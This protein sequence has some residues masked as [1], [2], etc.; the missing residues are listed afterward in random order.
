MKRTIKWFCKEVVS[1]DDILNYYLRYSIILVL[2]WLDWGL[3]LLLYSFVGYFLF[4]KNLFSSMFSNT[5]LN[6]V[7]IIQGN[8]NVLCYYLHISYDKIVPLSGLLLVKKN[9]N[10]LLLKNLL[11]RWKFNLNFYDNMDFL[12]FF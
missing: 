6:L 1:F 4:K 10:T 8:K 5:E 12:L 7:R 2:G 9:S 11:W 3:S